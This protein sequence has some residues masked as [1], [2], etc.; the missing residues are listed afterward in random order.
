MF[1]GMM[2]RPSAISWRTNSGVMKSGICRAEA[3]ALCDTVCGALNRLCPADI[4]ARGD[5]DHLFGD[6]P[7]LGELI[8]RDGFARQ[9]AQRLV[10]HRELAGEVFTARPAIVLL[11]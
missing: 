11:V 1:D 2:A 8:L 10:R 7:C 4:L 5:I 3:L 6:D 9:A